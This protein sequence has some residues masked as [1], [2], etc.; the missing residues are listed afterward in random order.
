M[1][2]DLVQSVLEQQRTGVLERNLLAKNIHLPRAPLSMS[3]KVG[4]H[5]LFWWIGYVKNVK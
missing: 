3:E 2:P 1:L 5:W 4:V